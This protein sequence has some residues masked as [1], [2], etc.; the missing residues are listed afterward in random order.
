MPYSC[1]NI[2]TVKKDVATKLK[3]LICG[4]TRNMVKP[5]PETEVIGESGSR[6]LGV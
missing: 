3:G 1:E 4:V 6:G 5:G 2:F